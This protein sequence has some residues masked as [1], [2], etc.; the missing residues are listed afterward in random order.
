ML[1][2][3]PKI[4]LP[5]SSLS[6]FSSMKMC[7]LLKAVVRLCILLSV[8]RSSVLW[9][10]GLCSCPSARLSSFTIS[11]CCCV[12]LAVFSDLCWLCAASSDSVCWLGAVLCCV[13]VVFDSGRCNLPH[14]HQL[15]TAPSRGRQRAELIP[16]EVLFSYSVL[17]PPLYT[18]PFN[19]WATRLTKTNPFFPPL[20]PLFFF[21]FLRFSAKH[22]WD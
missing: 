11:L 4:N 16:T 5:T 6:N 10:P 19:F 9:H 14:G 7:H 20:F 21:L 15:S 8:G 3:S 13:P 2:Q 17:L 12:C 18:Y 1:S 22:V